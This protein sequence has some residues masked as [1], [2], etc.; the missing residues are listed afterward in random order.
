[1]LEW[2]AATLRSYPEIEAV[3]NTRLTIWGKVIIILLT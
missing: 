3:G 1:M 2:L